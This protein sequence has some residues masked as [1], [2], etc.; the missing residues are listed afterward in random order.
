MCVVVDTS[1]F[2]DENRA[3]LP[4]YL[5]IV[6]ETGL[7]LPGS[8]AWLETDAADFHARNR[9]KGKKRKKQG[10]GKKRDTP[11]D[12]GGKSTEPEEIDGTKTISHEQVIN[13]LDKDTL[14]ASAGLGFGGR[15]FAPGPFSQYAVFNVLVSV[16]NSQETL[17]VQFNLCCYSICQHLYQKVEMSKYR[18]GVKWLRNLLFF[19][20][21]DANRV[22]IVATKL[23]QSVSQ[24]KKEGRG[25]ALALIK[26]LNFSKSN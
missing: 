23:A 12:V 21:L 10:R 1:G 17:T 25:V 19:P 22:Q 8:I 6:K 24:K 7:Q 16:S 14:V 18:K 20:Q 5:K 15:A 13:Q 2:S 9:S 26:D 11:D 3:Y 4:L